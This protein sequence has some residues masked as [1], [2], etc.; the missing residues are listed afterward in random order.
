MG[1]DKAAWFVA[2]GCSVRRWRELKAALERHARDNDVA[3]QRDSP[4]GFYYIVEG[5]LD[6]PDRRNPVVRSVWLIRFGEDFPRFV[7]AFP[8]RR[9]A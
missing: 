9:G 7:T 5:A 1:K 8:A 2:F 3:T 6:T 4:H